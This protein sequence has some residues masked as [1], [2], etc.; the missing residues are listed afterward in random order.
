MS[1]TMQQ[2]SSTLPTPFY[3]RGTRLGYKKDSDGNPITTR[4]NEQMLQQ[5][6]GAG[7]G[8]YVHGSNIS[9]GLDDILER[10]GKLEKQN[11]DEQMFSEYESK[12]QYPLIAAILLLAAELLIFERRNK[13]INYKNIFGK[14]NDKGN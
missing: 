12:F 7:N 2:P 1:T 14:K 9:S 4:L 6:A 10:I 11:Y 5:I 3:S 8:I 13:F